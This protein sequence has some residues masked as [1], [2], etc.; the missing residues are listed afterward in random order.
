MLDGMEHHHFPDHRGWTLCVTPDG[1]PE[2]PRFIGHAVRA[3]RPHRVVMAE[4]PTEPEPPSP[5]LRLLQAGREAQRR[6]A[7]GELD[8]LPWSQ[9]KWVKFPGPPAES[10]PRRRRR[11]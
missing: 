2:E 3:T 1:P 9:P 8:K 4:A 6:H 7:A 10:P 5:L 11:R